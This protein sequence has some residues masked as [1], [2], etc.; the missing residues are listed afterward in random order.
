MIKKKKK[1]NSLLQMSL[2]Q[3]NSV[4]H[5]VSSRVKIKTQKL[6]TILLQH[7]ETPVLVH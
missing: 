4:K 5:E 3:D 1:K 6:I 2:T 7:I